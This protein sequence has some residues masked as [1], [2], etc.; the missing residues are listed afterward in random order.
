M[1][2]CFGTF[3]H[4]CSSVP[5]FRGLPMIRF[6]TLS[7]TDPFVTLYGDGRSLSYN[8]RACGLGPAS[9]L[10]F[11]LPIA[12]QYSSLDPENIH[13]VPFL[14]VRQRAI[15]R[16]LRTLGLNLRV[17][18]DV[19]LRSIDS[20]NADVTRR[21]ILTGRTHMFTKWKSERRYAVWQYQIVQPLYLLSVV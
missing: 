10:A 3:Q 2:D 16:A 8:T 17:G 11:Y 15:R 14:D 4:S 18:Q 5:R 6:S 19:Y 20:W 1:Q 9:D 21:T 7:L 12:S 13:G